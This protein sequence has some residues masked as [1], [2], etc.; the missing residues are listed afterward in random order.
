MSVDQIEEQIRQLTDSD[1]SRFTKWFG[2]YLADRVSSP[3][4][5]WQE[6]ADQIAELDRR[7]A[8]F[9]ADPT[10]ATPF[11]SD[12][13]DNLKRQLADDRAKKASAC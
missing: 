4:L 11:K 1:L 10:L 6:S 12:Y 9:K 13:F 7:L 8:E 2:E 5:D 3:E